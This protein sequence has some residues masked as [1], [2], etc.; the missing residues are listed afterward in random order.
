MDEH[1]NMIDLSAYRGWY[2]EDEHRSPKFLLD[3]R[4]GQKVIAAK[5]PHWT[6]SEFP[7]KTN[8]LGFA[9]LHAVR[10]TGA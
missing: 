9:A 8:W 5:K 4:R 10:I 6:R 2:L 7:V 1:E 3:S